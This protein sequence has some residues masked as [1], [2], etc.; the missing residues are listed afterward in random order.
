[1]AKKISKR[2]KKLPS[3]ALTRGGDPTEYRFRIDA[4]TPETMP[5]ARLAEYLAE[6]AAILGEPTAVHLV[7]L[8][9]GSTVLV[10]E[11]ER[12]AVPKVRERATSVQRG[13]GPRDAVR[14]YRAINR[15]LRDD[16]GVG[17]LQEKTGAE[18]IRFP[19]REETE[20]KF[21]AIR[22]HGSLDGEVLRVGGPQKY[23]PVML[24]SEDQQIAGCWAERRI[25]KELAQR[26]FEP[27]RLFGRGLWTR[28]GD[29]KWNL[30]RF[31]VESFEA[32]RSE[33]LSESLNRLRAIPAAWGD[34]A[35]AGLQVMR[36]G[37]EKQ[38]GGA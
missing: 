5:M 33:T 38:N 18:I 2:G 16:N 7:R 23:V 27:V 24:Q 9:A 25:A 15:L 29:G 13:R 31:I 3:R 8:E 22:Q 21:A 37:P 11:I 26:L 6:L 34:D 12:E 19:G 10:H 20:E 36:H 4:Y 17:V 1:M 35:Y 28:D 32:L 14:A 30:E